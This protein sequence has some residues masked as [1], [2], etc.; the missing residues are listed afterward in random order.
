MDDEADVY[1][2]QDFPGKK[3]ISVGFIAWGVFWLSSWAV[4]WEKVPDFAKYPVF[5]IL[6]A[7]TI[8]YFIGYWRAVIGKGYPG[9]IW[10]ASLTGI[11]GV[12]I[13]FFLPNKSI[14][15][16]DSANPTPRSS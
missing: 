6:A 9:I 7:A 11:I 5:G 16:V 10:L 2:E 1:R 4:Q 14:E 15:Q 8:I 13:I 12:I 3:L